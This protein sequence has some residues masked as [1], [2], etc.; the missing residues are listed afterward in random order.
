MKKKILMSS[1]IYEINER[2]LMT[3]FIKN[4]FDYEN[5]YD[6][7]YLFRMISNDKEVIFDIYDNVTDNRFNR[8]VFSFIDKGYD[9]KVIEEG[10]VFVNYISVLDV[11]DSDNKLLKL[12]YLFKID[13]NL[14]IDYAK[15]FLDL[16][17]V[18]ILKEIIDK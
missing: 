4:I 13:D 8:Y 14:M 2:K 3:D 17:F 9:F 16:T 11:K 15:S 7:N 1:F 18:D 5:F 10:N 12:A 6:Y